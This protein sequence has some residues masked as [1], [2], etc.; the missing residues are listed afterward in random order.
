[1]L[2]RISA[3]PSSTRGHGR[4]FS[5]ATEVS[6]R[7]EHGED[8]WVPCGRKAP[9]S[10]WFLAGVVPSSASSVGSSLSGWLKIS[11]GW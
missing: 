1:M 9:L 2:Y 11:V 7:G 6:V 3:S 4:G 5:V 10:P 8:F